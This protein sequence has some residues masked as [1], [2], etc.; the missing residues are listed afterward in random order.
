MLTLHHSWNST[1]SQK[2][3]ICLAEKGLAWDSVHL[4]LRRL[5]Q[6]KPEFL[7]LNPAGVVPVLVHDDRVVFESTAINH[8][9]DETFPA[10]RLTPPA[11]AE[12]Q[13]MAMWNRYIDEVP[14]W[15]IKTPSFAQNIRPAASRFSAE[16]IEAIRSRMP[17][18]TTAERWLKAAG[19]GFSEAEIRA[20]LD[21]LADMLDRIEIELET[22][23]WLAGDIYSLADVNM[24]PFV[25]R[26]VVLGHGAMVKARPRAA[27]WY[28]RVAARPAFQTGINFPNPDA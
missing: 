28:R 14:T 11:T 3:R 19:P 24:A 27:H 10:V 16:Q 6:L 18:P 13:R 4:N 12:R 21:R 5:D 22:G 7:R 9:L 17:N 2:V 15:A 23:P 26:L 8:Y 20:D 1:C 25:H